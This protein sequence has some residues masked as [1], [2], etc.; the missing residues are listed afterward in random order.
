MNY[1][2]KLLLFSAG[3]ACRECITEFS[4]LATSFELA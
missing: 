3:M 1:D 4:Y 2:G